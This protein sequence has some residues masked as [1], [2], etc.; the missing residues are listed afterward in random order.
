MY[1]LLWLSMLLLLL[2]VAGTLYQYLGA[3]RDRRRYLPR[4]RMVDIGEGR[5][6]YLHQAGDAGPAVIFE[7]GIGSTSQNWFGLQQAVSGFARTVAYDRYGL[8][9]SSDCVTERTPSNIVRELRLM[10]LAAGIAPPYILVGHSFGGLVVRRYAADFPED[11]AGVVLV[12]A[13][14]PEE[15]PPLKP[16]QQALLDRGIRQISLGRILARFGVARLV[17]TSLLRHSNRTSGVVS[18][19]ARRI[20]FPLLDRITTEL[21]KMPRTVWP[22]V[23]AHWSNPRFYRD[24]GAYLRAVP[25]TVREMQHAAPIEGVPVVLFTPITAEALGAD[26]LHRIGPTTQQVIAKKSRH[27]VHLDEPQIVVD[28]IRRMAERQHAND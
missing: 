11:V 9:W 28:A 20:R 16:E 24:M 15:W 26:A 6:L 4:G 13:M 3:R 23:A 22:V 5:K 1:L 7:S 12:D 21:G 25:A 17:A 19:V 10:L 27:W 2:L 8:G 18:R 14:R